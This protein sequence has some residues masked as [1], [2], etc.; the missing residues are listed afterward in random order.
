ML[1]YRQE[2]YD[3]NQH[4]IKKKKNTSC[5]QKEVTVFLTI[6]SDQLPKHQSK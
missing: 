6:T 5:S 4:C 3:E 1:V 2:V